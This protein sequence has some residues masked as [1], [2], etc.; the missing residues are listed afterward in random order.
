MSTIEHIA[1]RE[2]LDSRGN[3]TVEVALPSGVAYVSATGAS[4]GATGQTVH[5]TWGSDLASGSS[6][7]VVITAS[8]G[9]SVTGTVTFTATASATTDDPVDSNNV[10]SVQRA[11]AQAPVLAV[12]AQ[13]VGELVMGDQGTIRVAVANTGTGPAESV[14]VQVL[15]PDGLTPAGP[16]ALQIAAAQVGLPG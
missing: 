8:V 11:N 6:A 2:V 7:T 4:C 13:P 10:A 16:G 1:G 5:C 3:P 14:T 9:G 12:Q 15:L